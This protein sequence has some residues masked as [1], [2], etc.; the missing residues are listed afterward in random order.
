MTKNRIIKTD[1]KF[2]GYLLEH[3]F[4]HLKLCSNPPRWLA[5]SR[6]HM[7]TF[8]KTEGWSWYFW[9]GQFFRFCHVKVHDQRKLKS[10]K[11]GIN[12]QF[13]TLACQEIKHSVY[14][15]RGN[16]HIKKI[17]SVKAKKVFWLKKIDS[18]PPLLVVSVS[19]ILSHLLWSGGWHVTSEA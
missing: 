8:W 2:P 17:C 3:H 12:T 15:L 11:T 6:C 10:F 4:R 19:Q 5:R 13:K 18:F 7:D 9:Q 1:R 16:I 14:L